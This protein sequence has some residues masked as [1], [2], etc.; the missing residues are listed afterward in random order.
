MCLAGRAAIVSGVGERL[1]PAPALPSCAIL[2]VNPGAALPTPEVFAA[3]RGEFSI[4]QP[5]T[6][7]WNDL[8]D[9][10]AALARRGNDLTDAAT[11]LRPA[12]ADVL[13]CLRQSPRARYAAM[14]GSGATCFALYDTLSAAEQ[15]AR[16]LPA[17]WWRHAGALVS[18]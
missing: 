9:L 12:I 11:A 13:A 1:E 4:V 15:A 6:Q 10:V 2:L 5:V 3:R 17:A 8:A 14:S 7:P 18:G 16:G